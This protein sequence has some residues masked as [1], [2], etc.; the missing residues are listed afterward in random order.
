[1]LQ[2]LRRIF[3]RIIPSAE[4]EGTE[5]DAGLRDLQYMKNN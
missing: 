3:N 2:A 1:M 4:D 5:E